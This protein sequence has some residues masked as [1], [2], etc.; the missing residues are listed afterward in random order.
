MVSQCV[1]VGKLACSFIR[2]SLQVLTILQFLHSR[3]ALYIILYLDQ[4]S[5]HSHENL[6]EDAKINKL[7]GAE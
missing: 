3:V 7:L 6:T 5:F 1:V 4:I 2:W